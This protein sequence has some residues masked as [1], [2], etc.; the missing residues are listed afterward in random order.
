M[1][2]KIFVTNK[3]E[4]FNLIFFHYSIHALEFFHR[5]TTDITL[6]FV[7]VIS[8]SSSAIPRDTLIPLIEER[9]TVRIGGHLEPD[10]FNRGHINPFVQFDCDGNGYYNTTVS[11]VPDNTNI[12]FDVSDQ[13]GGSSFY[14][15]CL[16]YRSRLS[17]EIDS[18]IYRS[19]GRAASMILDP[20]NAIG[21][22]RDGIISYAQVIV[23]TKV[24]GRVSISNMTSD[25]FTLIKIVPDMKSFSTIP[26][27]E[28]RALQARIREIGMT[29]YSSRNG[30]M[31]RGNDCYNQLLDQLPNLCYSLVSGPNN[32]VTTDLVFVPEDFIAQT[33]DTSGCIL[34]LNPF[35]DRQH[36]ELH[37][38]NKLL[39]HLG[40]IHLDY[41]NNRVG[42][43]DPV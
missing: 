9:W 42:F 37:L 31:I 22:A 16:S 6:Y 12:R 36:T 8:A 32:N 18:I 15:V 14:G 17:Q 26:V 25:V 33:D 3:F 19:D 7:L 5:M 10:I 39:R 34:E 41:A 38:T 29:I 24:R 20:T 11:F 1:R 23:D 21:L 13:F 35:D 4:K 43:F 40:G 2:K 28:F 30:W 27:V